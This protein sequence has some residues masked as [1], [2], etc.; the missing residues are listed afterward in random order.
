MPQTNP[1]LAKSTFITASATFRTATALLAGESG[2][3]DPTADKGAEMRLSLGLLLGMAIA[4]G[5]MAQSA[6]KKPLTYE[7]YRTMSDDWDYWWQQRKRYAEISARARALRPDRRNTPLRDLNITDDEMREVQAIAARFLPRA[8]VNISPVVTDCPCEEGPAC[9]AQVF[10]LATAKG[11]TTGLQ[12]SRMLSRWDVGVVQQW[13]LKM[14][15]IQRQNTGN[16]TLD[17]YLEA[18]ARN[19]LLEEF[20]ACV[21]RPGPAVKSAAATKPEGN[22]EGKK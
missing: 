3:Y 11:K 15:A 2:Q 7:Q 22:T 13:W 21:Q 16:T 17:D 1:G 18:K 19:E 8:L 6:D 9:T 12:L 14:D 5:V 20:P 10:V 4:A